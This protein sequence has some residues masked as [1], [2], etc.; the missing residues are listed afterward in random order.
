MLR[1]RELLCDTAALPEA[2]V[3]WV[4]RDVVY[5][6][7]LDGYLDS[8]AKSRREAS[9]AVR[10]RDAARLRRRRGAGSAR[11]RS[12]LAYAQSTQRSQ[13]AHVTE[14]RLRGASDRLVLD[15]TT[16]ANLEVLR[17]QREAERGTSLLSILDRTVTAPGGRLLRDWLRRPLRESAGIARRH[18]GVG[19]LAADAD[20]LARLR[21]DLARIADLERLATRRRR[22]ALS[23][24]GGGVARRARRRAAAF[25]TG[26]AGPSP[27]G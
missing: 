3:A 16:L 7:G 15:A 19:V 27:T 14:I 2:L 21:G 8:A 5:R 25:F 9:L 24:G 18:D 1:P 22:V 12:V 11:R 17:T 6:T 23:A 13:L 10:R 26:L 20:L 4:E